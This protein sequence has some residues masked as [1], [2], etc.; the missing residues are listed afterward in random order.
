[1]NSQFDIYFTDRKIF[2]NKI[3]VSNIPVHWKKSGS[4]SQS[5][6]G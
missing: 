2:L 4:R 6:A 3:R 5:A 1:M